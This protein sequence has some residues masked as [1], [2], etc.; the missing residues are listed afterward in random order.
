MRRSL[1]F[2]F[3][4]SLSSPLDARDSDSDSC[5]AFLHHARGEIKRKLR[6]GEIARGAGDP[7][8]INRHLPLH[9]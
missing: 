6:A 3:L 2:S 1:S 5:A 4:F 9:R 7:P 8:S